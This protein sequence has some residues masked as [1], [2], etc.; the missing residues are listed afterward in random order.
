MQAL[1]NERFWVLAILSVLAR[2]GVNME[3]GH[4]TLSTAK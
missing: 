2:Q 1:N 4:A 3:R